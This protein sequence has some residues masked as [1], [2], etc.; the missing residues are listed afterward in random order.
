MAVFITIEVS[1]AQSHLT[2]C[3]PIAYSPPRLLC[4]WGSPGKNTGVGCHS[5]LQGILLT[6]GSNLGFLHCRQ[7]L[8]HLIYQGNPSLLLFPVKLVGKPYPPSHFKRKP[9]KRNFNLL[10]TDPLAYI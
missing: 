1:I 5:L 10:F 4:P 3:D 2:F 6:Q 8:Y 9:L 7:I